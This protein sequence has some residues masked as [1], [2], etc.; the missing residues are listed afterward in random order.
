MKIRNFQEKFTTLLNQVTG[1]NYDI[2]ITLSLE[3]GIL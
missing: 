2:I 1:I 3:P